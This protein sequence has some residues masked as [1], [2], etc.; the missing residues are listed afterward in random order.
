MNLFKKTVVA[1]FREI[2]NSNVIT[3]LVS[4]LSII[5][6]VLINLLVNAK[7]KKSKINMHL[8]TELILV[9][10][11]FFEYS[12]LVNMDMVYFCLFSIIPV[13]TLLLF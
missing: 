6:L 7:L 8:P 10:P 1:V 13:I 9:S 3:V 4:M 11:N 12:N 2:S 5:A